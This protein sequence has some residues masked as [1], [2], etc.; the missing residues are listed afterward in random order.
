MLRFSKT[1]SVTVG[2][3]REYATVGVVGTV[4]AVFARFGH[5]QVQRLPLHVPNI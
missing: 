3:Y 1:E 4:F 2:G 5:I